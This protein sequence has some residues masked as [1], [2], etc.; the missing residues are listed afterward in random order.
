MQ[1]GVLGA[2][3]AASELLA[4]ANVERAQC[5][6]FGS[7]LISLHDQFPCFSMLF[8]PMG[9]ATYCCVR[10]AMKCRLNKQNASP[11]TST[12]Q[13]SA[14]SSNTWPISSDKHGAA[15][16]RL[17]MGLCKCCKHTGCK[18]LT[19]GSSLDENVFIGF[20]MCL[21]ANPESL[22]PSLWRGEGCA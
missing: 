3:N 21:P 6:C 12:K 16:T 13:S 8:S 18:C 20:V 7:S 1:D 11:K 2:Q 14:G 4:H 15:R 22:P 9:R 19:F 17:P 10:L 5:L